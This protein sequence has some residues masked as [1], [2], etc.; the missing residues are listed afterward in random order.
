MVKDH[1]IR[2]LWITESAPDT[3]ASILNRGRRGKI[4]DIQWRGEPTQKSRHTESC[5]ATREVM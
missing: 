5:A 4:T 3:V 1:K 2:S